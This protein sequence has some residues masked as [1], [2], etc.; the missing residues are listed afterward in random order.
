MKTPSPIETERLK[1]VPAT[2]GLLLAEKESLSALEALLRVHVP[3]PAAHPEDDI[4]DE[5]QGWPPDAL[6]EG[7]WDEL[8]EKWIINLQTNLAATGFTVWYVICSASLV[9]AVW[10]DCSAD[11]TRPE[12]FAAL[13]TQFR[14]KEIGREAIGEVVDWALGQEGIQAVTATLA[15][16][17]AE[18]FLPLLGFEKRGDG[19]IKE[20]V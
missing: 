11:S 5:Q 1:L 2:E 6:C 17:E 13:L 16:R 19:W 20:R 9:G 14:N 15:A 4:F 12:V 18:N 8:R 3:L 7:G 10:F